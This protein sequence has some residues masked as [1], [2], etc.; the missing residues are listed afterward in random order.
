MI[1]RYHWGLSVGHIYGHRSA[2][3]LKTTTRASTTWD[4]DME[5]TGEEDSQDTEPISTNIAGASDDEESRSE[6]SGSSD[7]SDTDDL[8]VDDT[9]L[10]ELEEMYGDSYGGDYD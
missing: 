9:E 10:L 5:D 1:M 7:G 3:A 8:D 2:Q 4:P 6:S